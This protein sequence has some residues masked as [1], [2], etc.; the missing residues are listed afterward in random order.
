[1]I[2]ETFLEGSRVDMLCTQLYDIC[3]ILV[4][5]GVVGL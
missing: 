4:L 5:D 2:R 1:V 3:F